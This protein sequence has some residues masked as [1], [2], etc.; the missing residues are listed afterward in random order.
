MYKELFSPGKLYFTGG[1]HNEIMCNPAFAEFVQNSLSRYIKG[2]WGDLCK[3]DKEQNKLSLREGFQLLS[4]YKND[5]HEIM[6]ITEAD[7]LTTTILFP[8]E[9]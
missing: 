2:D 9:Y 3:E 5:K 7:R 6:I 4:A 8:D 1:V